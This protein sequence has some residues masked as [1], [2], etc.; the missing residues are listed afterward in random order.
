MKRALR[1][2][3]LL[4]AISTTACGGT[5]G[6]TDL[7]DSPSASTNSSPVARTP[8]GSVAPTLTP[9]PVATATDPSD[10]QPSGLAVGGMANVVAD[11]VVVRTEP[12]RQSAFVIQPCTG[13]GGPCPNLLLGPNTEYQSVYLI[14]GPVQADGYEWYLA[15]VDAGVFVEN[16]GWVPAGDSVGPWLVPYQPECPDEPIELA[17]VTYSAISRAE[18]LACVGGRELTLRGWL[19]EPPETGAGND[20]CEPIEGRESFCDFGYAML[21]PLEAEWAGDANH[22]PWIGDAAAGLSVPPRDAW[23]TI[24]GRFDHP[25]S[26]ECFDRTPYAVFLCRLDFVVT[27]ISAP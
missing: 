18:L 3:L 10:P 4:L 19:P 17:D 13:H 22:L 5:A 20:V 1:A 7:T 21:R 14:D 25:A 8:S 11:S 27:S 16:V 23:V 12:G 15:A 9:I 24:R 2:A 6:D 26:A